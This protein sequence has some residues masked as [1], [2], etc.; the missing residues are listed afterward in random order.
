MNDPRRWL[1]ALLLF[2][3][4]AAVSERPSWVRVK[5]AR[6]DAVVGVGS[7]CGQIM[8]PSVHADVID[9]DEYRTEQ[10]KEGAYS[11]TWSFI[12]KAAGGIGLMLG[13]VALDIS[14]YEPNVEQ[15]ETTK[16]ALRTMMSLFPCACVSLAAVS[17][18]RFRLT[19]AEHT[20]IRLVLD[21]R[22]ATK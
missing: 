15:S 4:C 1:L 19:E 14:G 3:A 12:L 17:L 11:A 13:G 16:L 22:Q 18:L 2:A 21:R 9:Y 5:P 7:G 8:G 6:P 20:R 10:R